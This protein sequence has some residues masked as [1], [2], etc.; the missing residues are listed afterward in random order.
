MHP[1]PDAAASANPSGAGDS[2]VVPFARP[3]PLSWGLAL[4]HDT[5]LTSGWACIGLF[6]LCMEVWAPFPVFCPAAASM[7]FGRGLCLSGCGMCAQGKG[8]CST[9]VGALLPC[10]RGHP[11]HHGCVPVTSGGRSKD[12]ASAFAQSPDRSGRKPL[13]NR[14]QPL[15]CHRPPP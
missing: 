13:Q 2:E 15:L 7:L 1:S 3:V 4:L 11:V 9:P 5:R 8:P 12:A 14:P 10:P 6:L